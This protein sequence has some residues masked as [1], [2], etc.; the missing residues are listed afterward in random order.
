MNILFCCYCFL[1]N[2]F[3]CVILRHSLA[4]QSGCGSTI[5]AS[6]VAFTSLS[7]ACVPIGR[8]FGNSCKHDCT[9]LAPTIRPPSSVIPGLTR[10]LG[11]PYAWNCATASLLSIL[12]CASQGPVSEHGVTALLRRCTIAIGDAARNV[13]TI[14]ACASHMDAGSEA[15]MTALLRCCALARSANNTLI[16]IEC[17]P[18]AASV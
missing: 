16:N 13:S 6:T 17:R 5:C 4:R 14:L 9:H 1:F 8:R 2:V 11:W 7:F 18:P 10:N 12:A 15:G 3:I